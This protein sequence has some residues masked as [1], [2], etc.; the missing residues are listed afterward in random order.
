[1][2]H[3]LNCGFEIKLAT[4]RASHR[5]R[6]IT[7]SNPIEV[8]SFSGFYTKLLKFAFITAMI[9]ARTIFFC[10]ARELHEGARCLLFDLRQY[11]C[12]FSTF[13]GSL[14][15]KRAKLP[16]GT[17]LFINLFGNDGGSI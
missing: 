13:I 16:Q 8:L 14:L 15:D 2:F 7:G 3:I 1:M 11:Y 17:V 6:E 5:Y 12:H 10:N 4:A 9:I